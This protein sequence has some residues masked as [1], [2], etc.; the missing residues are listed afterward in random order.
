MTEV[1]KAQASG[2]I[3]RTY[4]A[5]S[6]VLARGVLSIRTNHLP[7]YGLAF[8]ELPAWGKQPSGDD[9]PVAVDY[10]MAPDVRE[11]YPQF[12]SG[13]AAAEGGI[14][15]FGRKMPAGQGT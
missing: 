7:L 8:G 3:M 6:Y 11:M 4:G 14:V 10:L 15:M 9:T 13:Q 5:R 2:D 1:R 12:G